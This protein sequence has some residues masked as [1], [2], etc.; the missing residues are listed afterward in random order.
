M[1]VAFEVIEPLG[2]PA[3]VAWQALTDWAGHGSWVPSTRVRMTSGDGGP[4]STFV[5]RTEIGPL[6]FDDHMTVV[7]VDA[8]TRRAVVVKTGPLLTGTAGFTVVAAPAGSTL[9]WFEDVAVRGV[10]QAV[11][12]LARPLSAAA[13]RVAIGR[14]RRQLDTSGHGRS[15]TH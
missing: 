3:D 7:D 6:A 10:P 9:H 4:G 11:A 15:R 14:L 12:V 1:R 8:A 2:V 5:A 13:F